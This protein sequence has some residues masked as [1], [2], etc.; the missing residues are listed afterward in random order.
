MKI[1]RVKG[2]V[3]LELTRD[4]TAKFS[5]KV[6]YAAPHSLILGHYWSPFLTIV[7]RMRRAV[8]NFN[9]NPYRINAL[10]PT[11]TSD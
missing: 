2:L 4:V 3:R 11:F 10:L 6:V 8:N 9:P 1:I 5:Y 7:R